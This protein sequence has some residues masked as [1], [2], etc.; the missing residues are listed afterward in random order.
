LDNGE[1]LVWPFLF[2]GGVAGDFTPNKLAAASLRTASL[3]ARSDWLAEACSAF[4]D[5]HK[6]LWIRVWIEAE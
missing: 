6:N 3:P 5:I 4:C 1:Q 2:I